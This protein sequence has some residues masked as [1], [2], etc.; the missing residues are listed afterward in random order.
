MIHHQYRWIQLVAVVVV[1]LLLGVASA[2]SYATVK[3]QLRAPG[4]GELSYEP[5]APGTYSLPVI[6]AASD[7]EVLTSDNSPSRLFDLMSDQVVFLSFIFTRCTDNNGCPLANAVLHKVQARLNGRPDLVDKVSLLTISFDPEY[8][9]PER[10]SQLRDVY[11]SG[12]AS[13][14]FL[15]SRD[16][17]SLQPILDGYGQYPVRHEHEN[18]EGHQIVEYAHLLRVYLIDPQKQIRNIYSVAFLHPDILL[19]DLE[20]LLMELPAK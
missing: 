14:K 18:Q 17:A 5:P 12:T 4:W 10:L 15:T 11:S 19:N 20:T 2:L 1:A 3:S 7:G 6:K 16:A 9:T 8:D 13:W